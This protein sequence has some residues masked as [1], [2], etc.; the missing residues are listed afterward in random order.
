[1]SP[2]SPAHGFS[3][4]FLEPND[5]H[6][7]SRSCHTIRNRRFLRTLM[8]GEWIYDSPARTEKQGNSYCAKGSS[9]GALP[10]LCKRTGIQIFIWTQDV[11]R[12]IEQNK[13]SLWCSCQNWLKPESVYR[14]PKIFQQFFL[15]TSTLR[16]ITLPIWV[17]GK[18]Y[19]HLSPL[20]PHYFS[21][22]DDWGQ[23]R[24][25]K[26]EVIKHEWSNFL[27]IQMWWPQNK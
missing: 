21:I 3:F 14:R 20:V 19:S 17:N 23:G 24:G 25:T 8:A 6:L 12:S 11:D 5:Y 15:Q 26:E 4:H 18:P 27:F 10:L 16:L 1:M 22:Y 9:Y 2:V 13:S 7:L